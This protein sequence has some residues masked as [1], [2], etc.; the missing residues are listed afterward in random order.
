MLDGL[1]LSVDVKKVKTHSY[2]KI[3]CVHWLFVMFKN[4]WGIRVSIAQPCDF[5][6][7]IR[8]VIIL[9]L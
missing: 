1:E 8:W 9:G 3:R 6:L 4:I 7:K 2:F 5:S